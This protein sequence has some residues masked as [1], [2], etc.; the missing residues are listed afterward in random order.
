[1]QMQNIYGIYIPGLGDHRSLGQYRAIR[2]WQKNGVYLQYFPL[3]WSDKQDWS[4]KEQR[5]LEEVDRLYAE[6]GAPIVLV[7]S[8]AGASAVINTYVKRKNKIKAVVYICGK[9]LNARSVGDHIFKHNPAFKSSL[10][11]LPQN[12]K[13]LNPEDKEKILSVHS[14]YDGRVPTADTIIEGVN[15]VTIHTVGHMLSIAYAISFGKKKIIRFIR[16]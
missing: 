13:N 16:E 11:L 9:I 4:E 7:G 5:I 1:M 12:I 3:N 8:S 14:L 15:D 2:S 10:Q 6:H